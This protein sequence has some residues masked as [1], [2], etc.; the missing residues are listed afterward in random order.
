EVQLLKQLAGQ[1]GMLAFARKSGA[2]GATLSGAGSALLVLTRSPGISGLEKRLAGK[3]ARLWGESG[4]IL[5]ARPAARGAY[6]R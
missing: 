4:G 2:L 5:R 6:F 1:K 3:A